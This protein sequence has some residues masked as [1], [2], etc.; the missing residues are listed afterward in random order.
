MLR[1]LELKTSLSKMQ[2]RNTSKVST[3]KKKKSQLTTAAD[4]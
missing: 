2:Q 1:K 4:N 3:V